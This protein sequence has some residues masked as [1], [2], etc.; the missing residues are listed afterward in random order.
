MVSSLSTEI[1]VS[2]TISFKY[3]FDAQKAWQLMFDMGHSRKGRERLGR[4][5]RLCKGS[6]ALQSLKDVEDMVDWAAGAWD[7][8]GKRRLV[9]YYW[10]FSYFPRDEYISNAAN[11]G[12]LKKLL[13]VTSSV[14]DVDVSGSASDV[15]AILSQKLLIDIVVHESFMILVV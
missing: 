11:Q 6:T 7:Y 8:L 1:F 2:F 9:C 10:Y 3:L 14:N 13:W 4:A 5:M 15:P 12:Q